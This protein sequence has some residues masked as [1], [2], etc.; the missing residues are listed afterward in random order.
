MIMK[1]CV[2]M[3]NMI[4]EDEGFVVDPNERFEDGGDNVEPEHGH[5]HRTL[6]E[7]IEAHKEIRSKET[8]VQLKQ[9]LI[10]HLW[11]RHPDLY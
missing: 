2:I 10:E 9:D 5:P 3:H 8:H 7:F 6:Q 4:V 1:A 11:N